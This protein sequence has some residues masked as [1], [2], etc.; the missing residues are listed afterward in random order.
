VAFLTLKKSFKLIFLL[1][2]F[3]EV[4]DLSVFF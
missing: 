3:C 1:L 2:I 4:F